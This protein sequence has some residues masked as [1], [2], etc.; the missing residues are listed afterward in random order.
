MIKTSV[1]MSY[2]DIAHI[3][4]SWAYKYYMGLSSWHPTNDSDS[5]VLVSSPFRTD[6]NPSF[7]IYWVESLNQYKWKDHSDGA[8]GG[9]IDLVKILFNLK[10]LTEIYEKLINDYNSDHDSIK[11][12]IYSSNDPDFTPTKKLLFEDKGWRTQ[13]YE[14]WLRYGV[15][16]QLLKNY[17][18]RPIK[19]TWANSGITPTYNHL[20]WKAGLRYGFFTKKGQL[21][22]VYAPTSTDKHTT[23]MTHQPGI[24]QLEYVKPNLIIVSSMKDLLVF[25]TLGFKTF[26]V[27]ASQSENTLFPSD[28]MANFKLMYDRV[29]VM[30]DNDTPGIKSS[31]RW[32]EKFDIY[33]LNLQMQKDLALT[34][35]TKGYEE[36]KKGLYWV[37]KKGIGNY[38][39]AK[40]EKGF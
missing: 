26:E 18:I 30:M 11:G 14:Y 21:Y 13:D 24:E 6:H 5:N 31:K 27:V 33:P 20:R 4:T 7:S 39:K 19:T 22:K 36:T 16:S 9:I 25:K 10:N 38:D 3:P 23:V 12:K 29:F 2:K 1:P 37:L 17:C 8:T 34:M 40:K 32:A 28:V 15:Q 35:F